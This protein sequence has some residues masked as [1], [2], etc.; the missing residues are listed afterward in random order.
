MD[1]D[2]ESELSGQ[3]ILDAPDTAAKKLSLR[4][5]N[6][7][8]LFLQ[9]DQPRIQALTVT[10][11]C[12][13]HF[14]HK[15]VKNMLK[16]WQA[17]KHEKRQLRDVLPVYELPPS[18]LQTQQFRNLT[19][20]LTTSPTFDQGVVTLTLYITG[21]FYKLITDL[22]GMKKLKPRLNLQKNCGSYPT[23]DRDH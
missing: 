4:Y 15:S 14:T 20:K 5:L 13:S 3:E 23:P 10:L 6:K 18:G 21:E 8:Q 1:S 2:Y 19:E 17:D 9:S 12:V 22:Q 16:M 11:H 7:W